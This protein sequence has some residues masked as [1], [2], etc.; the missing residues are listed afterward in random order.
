MGGVRLSAR[1]HP[2]VVPF[3]QVLF[4]LARLSASVE[5]SATVGG[6]TTTIEEFESDNELAIEAG[7]GVNIRLTERVGARFGASYVR[8]GGDDGGN[9]FRVA[10]G[11]VVPF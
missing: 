10:A 5:G 1:R 7:G 8:F 11:I 9:A 3:A 4:G 6:Q 2:R